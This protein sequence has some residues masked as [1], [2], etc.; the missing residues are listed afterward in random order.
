MPAFVTID[1]PEDVFDTSGATIE[2]R[3]RIAVAKFDQ[4]QALT[5]DPKAKPEQMYQLLAEMIPRWDGV[6]S[7]ETDEPLPNPEEDHTVFQW[8]DMTEQLPWL[9]EVCQMSPGK[10]KK[11]HGPGRT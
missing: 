10:L 11:A 7:V 4:I 9:I 2:R 1:L 6:L 3:K 5:K 8:L